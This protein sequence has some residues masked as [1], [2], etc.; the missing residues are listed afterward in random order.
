[1][2]RVLRFNEY[3][4]FAYVFTGLAAMLV[5]D[6]ALGTQWILR[7]QWGVPETVAVVLAAYVVGHVVA[8]PAAWL[9]ERR[10][11]RGLL[12]APCKALFC[13]APQG[14]LTGVKR[15]LFPDYFTPLDQAM[16]ERVAAKVHMEGHPASSGESLFWVA[17]SR[18]RRDPLTYGRMESFLKLYGFC[19]NIAFVGFAAAALL[20]GHAIWLAS[21]AAPAV[22]LVDRLWWALL[23]LIA[24]V[25]MLYRYLKF[26]RLYSVEV[27]TEYLELPILEGKT[28][29]AS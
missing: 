14:V 15:F 25:V 26:H 7:T 17:F 4:L 3:E 1:M 11:V 5:G 19:R 29:D 18:A 21:H 28:N 23:A 27:F 9:L 8:W 2:E 24:G 12:G 20:V 16:R 13:E 6:V 22:E 10:L